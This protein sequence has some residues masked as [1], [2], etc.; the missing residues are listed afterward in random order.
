V[1]LFDTLPG[2]TTMLSVAIDSSGDV[3]VLGA[4]GSQQQVYRYPGGDPAARELLL[5]QDFLLAARTS[6]T[7]TLDESSVYVANAGR[8]FSIDAVSGALSQLA[9]I[10]MS[11]SAGAGIAVYVPEPGGL[12]MLLAG[13][14]ALC[15]RARK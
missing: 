14:A 10:P 8:L 3:F 6:M 4:E 15:R 1:A 11:A 2:S 5:D 12:A 7:L 13:A 9:T